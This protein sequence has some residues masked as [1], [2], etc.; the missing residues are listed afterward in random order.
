VVEDF[1]AAGRAV[2]VAKDPAFLDEEEVEA[3]AEESED[4]TH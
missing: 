4:I 1:V 2:V 3:E